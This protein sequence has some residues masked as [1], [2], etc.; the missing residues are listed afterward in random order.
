[1][2]PLPP[3]RQQV[4]FF[5][6]KLKKVEKKLEIANSQRIFVSSIIKKNFASMK[7]YS[8]KTN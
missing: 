2:R 3:D 5:S 4:T 1:M 8:L 7:K 6:K